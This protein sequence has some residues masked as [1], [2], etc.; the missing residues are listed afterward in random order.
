MKGCWPGWSVCVSG[1]LH[2]HL[3][4]EGLDNV[5]T[6]APSSADHV[7]VSLPTWAL[8]LC[9]LVSLKTPTWFS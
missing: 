1:H 7:M 9:S 4:Q 5:G 2:P 3:H 6:E 8:V